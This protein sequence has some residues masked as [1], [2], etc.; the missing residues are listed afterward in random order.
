MR[1]KGKNIKIPVDKIYISYTDR[2][3]ED[4][5]VI[6][7]I[8]GFPFNKSMWDAQTEELKLTN[9]VITYDVRGHGD[10][11]EGD[12]DFSIALFVDDLIGLMDELKIDSAILCG[13]SMGGYIALQAMEKYPNRFEGLVLC[14]T[15][16]KADTP[17]AKEKRM[18]TIESIKKNGVEIFVDGMIKNLFAAQSFISKRPAINNV[19]EMMLKTSQSAL[20]K[21]LLA[22]AERAETCGK[23]PEI[24]V[25]VLVMAGYE[26]KITP[27]A[28]AR[29]LH[30]QIKN[31]RLHILNNAGHVANI[32]NPEDFTEQLKMFIQY[33]AAKSP[34]NVH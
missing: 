29:F 9:R 25:P 13:L 27:P 14:D 7:F 32:E 28:I 6:I 5:P 19:K 16:C 22:L 1:I 10:T 26:D 31:S 3:P 11:D 24:N 33:A 17:E 34:T 21:T 20:C 18:M 15:N 23:L 8:H 30:E 4:V 2:G 12:E